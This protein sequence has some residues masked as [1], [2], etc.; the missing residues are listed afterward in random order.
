[1]SPLHGCPPFFST[2]AKQWPGLMSIES[3]FIAKS[4]A[5]GEAGKLWAL[6]TATRG[7]GTQTLRG[8]R[9]AGKNISTHPPPLG[10]RLYLSDRKLWYQNHVRACRSKL[11][12]SPQCDLDTL[13]VYISWFV[14]S[15]LRYFVS[16]FLSMA[17]LDHKFPNSKTNLFRGVNLFYP[18][19]NCLTFFFFLTS[20][21]TIVAI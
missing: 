18:S 10:H 16:Y 9:C 15:L 17:I 4:C 11:Q 5:W 19:H 14:V 20:L 3:F 1:M 21:W 8:I 2:H 7:N 12:F 13:L 6:R